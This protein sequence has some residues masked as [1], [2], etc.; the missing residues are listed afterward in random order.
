MTPDEVRRVLGEPQE[1]LAFGTR[2]RW[3]YPDL[4]V[5]FENG[6]VASVRF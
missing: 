4:T 3:T 1:E 2:T 6:R 5:V